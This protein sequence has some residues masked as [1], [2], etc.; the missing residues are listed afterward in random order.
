[1]NILLLEVDSVLSLL[2]CIIDAVI[3]ILKYFV[4]GSSAHVLVDRR[5]YGYY[6]D[7]ADVVHADLI[8]HVIRLVDE[9]S[10]ELVCIIM[11]K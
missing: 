5:A 9:E 4:E 8:E 10:V 6:R 3:R 2:K 7:F 1:M 11:C